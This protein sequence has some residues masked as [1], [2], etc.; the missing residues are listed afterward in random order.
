MVGADS[1]VMP[2]A[3]E[4]E[5]AVPKVSAS[6][7]CTASEEVVARTWLG[8]G[9]GLGPGLGPGSVLGLEPGL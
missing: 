2:S 1:I 6:E 5:A 9:L 8:L 4:A 3:V 7:A